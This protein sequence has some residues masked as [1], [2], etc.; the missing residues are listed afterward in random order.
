VCLCEITKLKCQ[1]EVPTPAVQA[2]TRGWFQLASVGHAWVKTL[3]KALPSLPTHACSSLMGTD[4]AGA[5][6]GVVTRVRILCD[7][8]CVVC[9]EEAEEEGGSSEC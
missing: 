6:C 2:L 8:S 1:P 3:S 4:S 9:V 5:T 7:V